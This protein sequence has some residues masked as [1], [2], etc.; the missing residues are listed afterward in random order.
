MRGGRIFGGWAA[1][2]ELIPY[3]VA[4]KDSGSRAHL[5]GGFIINARWIGSSAYCTAER[6]PQNTV[7]VAGSTQ[8]NAGGTTYTLDEVINH[9][10][11]IESLKLNEVSALR[12]SVSIFFTA[13]VQPVG[14]LSPQFVMG[15]VNVRGKVNA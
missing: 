3:Q 7:V 5:C 2:P 12:T 6:T 14:G 9:E 10:G 13:A 15:G 1:Y 4:V 11:Y 8:L